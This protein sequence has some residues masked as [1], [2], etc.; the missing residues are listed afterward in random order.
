[1]VAKFEKIF[2]NIA[3]IEVVTY[4]NAAAGLKSFLARTG[5]VETIVIDVDHYRDEL[6]LVMQNIHDKYELQTLRTLALTSSGSANEVMLL[7][8]KGTNDVILKPFDDK[9]LLERV[10]IKQTPERVKE[11]AY[12]KATITRE[13]RTLTWCSEFEIG[14]AE[15]DDEHKAI[16]ERF[17]QL[18]NLMKK[19]Q[20]HDYYSD[21]VNFLGEYVNTHFA[22]E[23]ALQQKINYP[24]YDNHKKIH[25]TFK[26]Q[27]DTML[28]QTDH[29]DVSHVQLLKLNLFVKEWLTHHILEEDLK[30]GTFIKNLAS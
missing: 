26:S 2:Q 9:T 30:L 25:E 7:F 16:V 20:G 10:M 11:A 15:I 27:V 3:D 17:E 24:G 19:G 23:E 4:Q 29:Q 6:D 12:V 18:Y 13:N 5:D 1:M 8:K 21:F 28:L 14:V 22:H